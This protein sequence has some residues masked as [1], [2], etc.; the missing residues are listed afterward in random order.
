MCY[1]C[2]CVCVFDL[3]WRVYNIELQSF[4]PCRALLA[5]TTHT[6]D[7]SAAVCL[8]LGS[9]TCG[10]FSATSQHTRRNDAEPPTLATS[11]SVHRNATAP[12]SATAGGDGAHSINMGAGCFGGSGAAVAG[13]GARSMGSDKAG[14]GVVVAWCCSFRFRIGCRCRGG[15]RSIGSSATVATACAM[16]QTSARNEQAVDRT[17]AADGDEAW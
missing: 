2:V 9:G 17:A 15:Q 14:K 4:V 16:G 7:L 6:Y 8:D 3:A 10:Q 5:H 13:G 1:L 12:A 11:R